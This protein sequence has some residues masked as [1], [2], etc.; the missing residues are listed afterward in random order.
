LRE[1]SAYLL[2]R[3]FLAV[4]ITASH[5]GPRGNVT[6][7]KRPRDVTRHEHGEDLMN[8]QVNSVSRKG[9]RK[10][11]QDAAARDFRDP[12]KKGIRR[13]EPPAFALKALRLVTGFWKSGA[14]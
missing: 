14:G 3:F 6:G 8:L 4:G 13:L 9:A 5:A 12:R 2:G 11:W 1:R 10:K 7:D